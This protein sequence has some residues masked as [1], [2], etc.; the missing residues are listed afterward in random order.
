[1]PW[2]ISS[3]IIDP[4]HGAQ[5]LWGWGREEEEKRRKREYRIEEKWFNGNMKHEIVG[6][7]DDKRGQGGKELGRAGRWKEGRR[8]SELYRLF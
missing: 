7:R 3:F 8:I 5:Q 2:S 4:L 1:M 6:V